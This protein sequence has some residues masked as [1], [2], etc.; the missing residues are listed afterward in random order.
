[1]TG[2]IRTAADNIL[3]AVATGTADD[4]F[5]I[6]GPHASTLNG[7]SAIVI[8]TMQPS[9]TGVDVLVADRTLPME[10]RHPEGLFELTIEAAGRSPRDL[11]YRLRVHEHG[12]SRECIDPYR[13]AQVVGDFDLHLFSEGT[14]YRAWEKLGSRRLAVDGITGVH[15][16]VWAPNA[17][18]V[19]VIG[20]F[21]HWDGRVS[22]MRKLVPSGVW[23]I[24][25]PELP[26]RTCYKFEVRTSGGHLLHKTDPYGRYFEIPPNT[27]SVV[28][29]ERYQWRDT[30]WMRDRPSFDG[31]RERP[32]SV[33]EVHL[34]S[35]RRVPEENSRTLTYRE[36]A[37]TLVPYVRE[38]GYTHIELM[39]VMEHPFSGSWGYQV[40]GFFAPTS[41]HGTQASH[42]APEG[43]ARKA[44]LT[45]AR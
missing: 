7:Q 40:I 43:C 37:D 33:Y 36:L 45:R 35:W 6:L 39:P 9:A 17:Q 28:F 23:E 26:E 20:D 11:F 42:S 29:D 38:M 24:F 19:S 13:F 2:G 44:V 5:S 25:I 1:M 18:R 16:A 10:K 41:R 30:E 8:R 12:G 31:W 15:F 21:N 3:D 4:P 14:H 27:A 34:G 32:M 22:A